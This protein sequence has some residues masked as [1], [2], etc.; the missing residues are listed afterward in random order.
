MIWTISSLKNGIFLQIDKVNALAI[1]VSA[2]VKS[3]G[4]KDNGINMRNEI[5]WKKQIAH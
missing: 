3:H 2:L 5:I 1:I 4:Q